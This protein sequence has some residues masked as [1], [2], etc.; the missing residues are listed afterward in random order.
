MVLNIEKPNVSSVKKK[1]F[2]YCKF[3][4]LTH[5]GRRCVLQSIDDWRKKGKDYVDRYCKREGKG[6]PILLKIIKLRKQYKTPK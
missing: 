6:C 2:N 1:N 5:D 4:V 3:Y